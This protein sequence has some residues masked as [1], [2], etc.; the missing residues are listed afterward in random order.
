MG[1]KLTG[2]RGIFFQQIEE[3]KTPEKAYNPNTFYRAIENSANY[4]TDF[5]TSLHTLL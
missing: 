3:H 2:K 5:L 1:T 4:T